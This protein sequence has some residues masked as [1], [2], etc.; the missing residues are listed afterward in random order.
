MAVKYRKDMISIF[1]KDGFMD[2]KKF[3]VEINF[4]HFREKIGYLVE[5]EDSYKADGIAQ[6]HFLN[7]HPDEAVLSSHVVEITISLAN[8]N[9]SQ[10]NPEEKA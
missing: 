5:A 8:P 4:N 10:R 6:R 7:S 1:E 3:A 2:N 9:P